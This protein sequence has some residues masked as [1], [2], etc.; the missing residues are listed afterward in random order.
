MM[1][2][3]WPRVAPLLGDLFQK[4][5]PYILFFLR[6]WDVKASL[7][8][9]ILHKALSVVTLYMVESCVQPKSRR[10]ARMWTT[11]SPQRLSAIYSTSEVNKTS[12]FQEI[13]PSFIIST[14]FHHKQKPVC[15]RRVSTSSTVAPEL[16][17]MQSVKEILIPSWVSRR[18]RS[19]CCDENKVLRSYDACDMCQQDYRR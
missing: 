13:W 14:F 17:R 18:Y 9:F 5:A 1:I 11:S 12:D 16:V 6:V 15:E 3:A 7:W 2:T 8:S 10:M 4:Y 19:T